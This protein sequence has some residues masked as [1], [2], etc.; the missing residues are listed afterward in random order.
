M[1]AINVVGCSNNFFLVK[2]KKIIPA[3]VPLEYQW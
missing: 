1:V 3:H 2:I